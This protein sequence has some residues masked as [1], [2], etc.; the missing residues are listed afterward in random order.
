MTSERILLGANPGVA[1]RMFSLQSAPADK[2]VGESAAWFFRADRKH[3]LEHAAP[4]GMRSDEFVL[5]NVFPWHSFAPRL[6]M[7]SNRM[8]TN[9]EVSSKRTYLKHLSKPLRQCT[10]RGCGAGRCLSTSIGSMRATP[11]ERRVCALPST[12]RITSRRLI[13]RQQSRESNGQ[14]ASIENG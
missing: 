2:Q 14:D 13:L 8:P 11:G 4:P 7:L 9:A 3:C 1:P 5:W 6:G 10:C 12:D